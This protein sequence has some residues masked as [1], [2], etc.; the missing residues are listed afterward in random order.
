MPELPEVETVVRGLRGLVVGQTI[1][2][3]EVYRERTVQ[4]SNP[5]AFAAAIHGHTIETVTRRAKYLLFQLQPKSVLLGHLRMTGKFVVAEPPAE[6]A[7]H[8]RAWF[9][10]SNGQV[11]IF[12]DMR[13]FGTLELFPSAAEIPK[14]LVLGPEPLTEDFDSRYLHSRLKARSKEIK[15]FLLDQR[16]VAGIGNIYASEILFASGI[17]PQRGSYS[18]K[19][20]EVQAIVENTRRILLTAIE[21][22]GTS[23][24]DFRQVDEKTGEFQNFLKVYDKE[25]QPCPR[26]EVPLQRIVQQQ[27]S[28]FFCMGCQK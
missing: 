25:S 6:P 14:L 21:H 16:L 7:P 3:A 20:R 13:N 28:T 22:N 12:T 23:V 5:K 2:R 11:L 10:L 18:L 9:W 8:D 15:P 1:Q 26:C 4:G 24:S 19:N 17:H 27:R